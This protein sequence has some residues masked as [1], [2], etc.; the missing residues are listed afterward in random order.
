MEKPPTKIIGL[1][2]KI[3]EN[4]E[5][6][7]HV[8]GSNRNNIISPCVNPLDRLCEKLLGWDFMKDLE[9]NLKHS[10]NIQELRESRS[11]ANANALRPELKKV[12]ITFNT[13]LEYLNIWEPLAIE[14]MKAQ[15]TSEFR[16]LVSDRVTLN[17]GIMQF[18]CEDLCPNITHQVDAIFSPSNKKSEW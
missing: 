11:A 1:R 16:G 8:S 13:Y 5:G 6:G 10:N 9:Q 15:I 7:S 14:E 4:R 12:P 2:P 17:T 18:T 3:K